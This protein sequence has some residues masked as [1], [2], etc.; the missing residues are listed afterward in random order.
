MKENLK[1]LEFYRKFLRRTRDVFM[2][3]FMDVMQTYL[4]HAFASFIFFVCFLDLWG[5]SKLKAPYTVASSWTVVG[6]KTVV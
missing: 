6:V 1:T 2:Q 3:R 4:G 5:F